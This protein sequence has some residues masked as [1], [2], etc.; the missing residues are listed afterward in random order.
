MKIRKGP[1]GI[2]LFNRETGTNILLD[3]I[4]PPKSSWS[5]S[6]RQVSIALTNTC[7]L[8]CSHCYAP[9][10]KA[11]LD[12]KTVKSWLSE[13]NE[14]GCFGIGFG[15]G[16]PT[17]HPGLVDICKHGQDHTELAITMTT[18]GHHLNDKLLRQLSEN[19]N[20]MRVSMDGVGEIYESIRGR[21]FNELL[22]ILKRLGKVIPFGLNYVVNSM[23]I[24]GISDA[25]KIAEDVG[26]SELLLLPEEGVGKGIK[27]DR[28]S[29]IYLKDWVS[30][31]CGSLQL[32][33]SSGYTDDFPATQTLDKEPKELVY[34]HIDA[35]GYLKRSS[36]DSHGVK[37]DN[38]DV[39]SAF[40][41]INK[42]SSGKII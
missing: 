32:A 11:T 15:G 19:V 38:I 33:I 8:T 39:M 21:S 42:Q 20:F 9:K 3:E 37:I 36:F 26:A 35:E 25:S 12:T 34:A 7:D 13:L 28:T 40:R 1:D 23:T 6:P 5:V 10:Q 16:E 22:K 41:N 27:I 24:K 30:N 4:I 18:H 17:L 29:F 14:H 31:Y 2:H